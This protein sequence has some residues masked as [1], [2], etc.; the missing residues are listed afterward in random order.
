MP[1][2][3]EVETVVRSVE[4]RVRGKLIRSV[5]TSASRV[6][7]GQ[8]TEMEREAPGQRIH[9]VTRIGKNILFQLDRQ[10]LRVHLGMTGRLLFSEAVMTHPRARLLLEG[11]TGEGADGDGALQMIY[12]DARQFGRFQL[13]TGELESLGLGPD[14]LSITAQAFQAIVHRHRGSIKN[15]LMNQKLLS[16]MGNIYT[17]EALFQAKIHPLTPGVLVPTQKLQALHAAMIALL[18]EAIQQGGSSIS[19]YMDACGNKGSYQEQHQA[20]GR[21][22]LPCPGC[23]TL[24][25]RIVVA[26]RGTHFCPQCQRLPRGLGKSPLAK[27]L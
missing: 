5:V 27:S 4:P 3:P 6:F 1:E 10:Q 7:G 8:Q 24:I 23:G 11:D 9:A 14:A 26:Q 19:D 25:T 20:Y 2:L 15:L 18:R 16:G 22:G 17:D 21:T 12:D 13:V